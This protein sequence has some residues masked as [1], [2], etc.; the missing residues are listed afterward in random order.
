MKPIFW[1][2]FPLCWCCLWP[3]HC[4]TSPDLQGSSAWQLPGSV[5]SWNMPFHCSFNAQLRAPSPRWITHYPHGSCMF[6][7]VKIISTYTV[8]FW[9]PKE[10][11]GKKVNT[12][13]TKITWLDHMT[14]S[15]K[16][17][18]RTTILDDTQETSSLSSPWVL[19]GSP[20]QPQ[21]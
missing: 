19:M 16:G 2:C 5:P 11:F 18:F 3:S 12:K 9:C 13:F 7:S 10:P 8:L 14:S 1:F 17:E 20:G 6:H 4:L 15:D 21:T